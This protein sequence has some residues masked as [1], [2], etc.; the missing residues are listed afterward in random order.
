MHEED[1]NKICFVT[2]KGVFGLKV[3]PFGLC[4]APLTFLNLV[5]MVLARL[6][7]KICPAYLNNL[8]VFSPMFQ[9][10]IDWLQLVFDCLEEADLK[11][12]PEKCSLFRSWVKFLGSIISADGS[13]PTWRCRHYLSGHIH[14]T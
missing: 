13:N 3:L 4:S 2:Q 9:R 6:T 12:R 14:R 10:D 8:T 5:D 1:V 7:W 11:L